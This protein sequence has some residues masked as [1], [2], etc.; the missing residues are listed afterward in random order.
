MNKSIIHFQTNKFLQSKVCVLL[1]AA[2]AWQ[3]FAPVK[4][5]A[6]KT[7]QLQR[8]KSAENKTAKENRTALVIGNSTYEKSPLTNPSN[9]AT[10]MAQ[11]LKGLDF[12]VISGVN[13]SFP[14]R[15]N[16]R[17]VLWR[18]SQ[19]VDTRAYAARLP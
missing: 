13:Q 9:D 17:V 6:Q 10:D 3:M 12:E 2:F 14:R 15:E 4:I 1:L 8:E 19:M 18:K 7:R 11:S 5:A 16:I